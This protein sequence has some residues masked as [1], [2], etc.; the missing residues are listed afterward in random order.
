L[1][2]EIDFPHVLLFYATVKG[3]PFRQ[4]GRHIRA[5]D[6]LPERFV[7]ELQEV[8]YVG[9]TGRLFSVIHIMQLIFYF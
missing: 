5:R 1:G 6:F 9:Q 7:I 8:G 4:F 3:E 2:D